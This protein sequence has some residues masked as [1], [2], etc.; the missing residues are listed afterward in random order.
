[1]ATW[2][3]VSSMEEMER[4]NWEGEGTGRSGM[5]ISAQEDLQQMSPEGDRYEAVLRAAIPLTASWRVVAPAACSRQ[6]LG[7]SGEQPELL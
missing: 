4:D 7:R 2:G 1:M 3:I 6:N 5:G